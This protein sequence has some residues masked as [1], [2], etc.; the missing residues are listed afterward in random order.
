MERDAV[1]KVILVEG[2]TDRERLLQVLDEPVDIISTYGTL[3]YDRLEELS[4][5]LYQLEVYILTDT[6]YAGK[7]LR[8]KLLRVLPAA[9][10][11]EVPGEYGQVAHAPLWYLKELLSKAGFKVKV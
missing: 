9:R 10:Q 8:K 7:E 11:L 4:D 1:L 5:S 6:D 3:S 2:K